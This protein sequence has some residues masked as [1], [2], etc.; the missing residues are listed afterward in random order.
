MCTCDDLVVDEEGLMVA[1]GGCVGLM[2]GS[3]K[4][5][6]WWCKNAVLME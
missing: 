6:V 3:G 4:E 1:E 5:N 2:I